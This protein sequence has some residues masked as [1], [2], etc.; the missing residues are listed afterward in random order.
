MEGERER[1]EVNSERV[2]RGCLPC[3]NPCGESFEVFSDQEVGDDGSNC[4]VSECFPFLCSASLS[5]L[6]SVISL[7][8]LSRKCQFE[9]FCD[10]DLSPSR[11]SAVPVATCCCVNSKRARMGY[12]RAARQAC[13][14]SRQEQAHATKLAFQSCQNGL[15]AECRLQKGRFCSR[16]RRGPAHQRT[17]Q[18]RWRRRR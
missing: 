17:C 18:M 10:A 11:R 1:V 7:A 4:D 13:A 3:L 6:L 2:R 16:L 15:G 14:R 12:R 9:P 5:L 8:V